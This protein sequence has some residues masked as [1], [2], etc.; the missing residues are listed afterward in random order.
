M[1]RDSLRYRVT[2]FFVGW[3]A[4]A[5]VVFSAA[6]YL[7]VKTFLAKS[8]EHTLADNA[9]NI[10]SH[11]VVQ[12]EARGE[13]WFL[14][15]MTEDFPPDTGD[16]FVR[17]TQGDKV[18]YTSGDM[19]NPYVS[20][21]KLPLPSDPAWVNAIHRETA[22]SGQRLMVYT[23]AYSAPDGPPVL[24]ESAATIDPIKHV[25]RSLFLILLLTTPIILVV[26]SIGG[27][28]LMSHS[29]RPVVVLTD[30]AERVGRKYMGERLPVI[31]SGDELERLS[32]SLNRMIDRLE[33]T[34]AHN[35][36]FSADASHEL[37]T[38]L[39]IIR[40]QLEELTQRPDLSAEAKDDV[41]SALEETDRMSHIVE[42]LMAI[43]RL[44]CGGER[45][46]MV[47]VD[48][49][50]MASVTVDQ[51]HLLADEKNISLICETGPPVKV[52]GDPIRLKQVMVNLLDNAIKYTASG[53]SVSVR[54]A[55][56]GE[57]AVMIVSDTGIG[58]P[59]E[60]L[61]FVFDRFYRADKARS[62]ESGG[63]GLGLA[64]V[65]SICS[66]HDGSISVKSGE[67]RGTTMRVDLPLLRPSQS[68]DEDAGKVMEP[69]QRAHF[70]GHALARERTEEKETRT[71]SAS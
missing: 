39:T 34:L 41:G 35:H 2:G 5:L 66:A 49:M 18:L 23:F 25:L 9:Q 30:Q 22:E 56:E 50:A 60:A 46:Q 37:R 67:G 53:G 12:R 43:T 14:K 28:A 62:R 3:L 29:L 36:R 55:A 15:E 68:D 16:Q 69:A 8:L 17:V 4:L 54:V 27:Y 26:A 44:D 51:M 58:I 20:T 70:P 65:K 71:A 63:V 59:E 47:P 31:R 38:P 24:V 52:A 57:R 21:S 11:Y 6:V 32:L 1:N 64:I 48:L 61:P 40:G 7:G 45:I 33:D 42:S 10:A 13:T 19:R